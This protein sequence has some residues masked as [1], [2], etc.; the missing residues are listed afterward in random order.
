VQK[1][2]IKKASFRDIPEIVC[3]IEELFAI[4]KDFV[5]D[6]QKQTNALKILLDEPTAVVLT[7]MYDN[8]LVGFASMQRVVSTSVGGY[9]GLIEDV[10]IKDGYRHQGIGHLLL[11]KLI[12]ESKKLSYKRLQLLCDITNSQAQDF[13]TKLGF[14]KSQMMGWYKEH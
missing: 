6:K 5:F 12:C 8:S 9:C 10:I 13:Y 4:E 1:T 2:F 11:E 3:L 7:A 14:T